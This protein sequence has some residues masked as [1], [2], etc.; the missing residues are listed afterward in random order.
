MGHFLLSFIQKCLGRKP[1]V[2]EYPYKGHVLWKSPAKGPRE[3]K[4]YRSVLPSS[5]A[6]LL[7]SIWVF[8]PFNA[9]ANNTGTGFLDTKLGVLGLVHSKVKGS[10][11][12]LH[13]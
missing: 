4:M 2:R 10:R 9:H 8:H 13:F 11:K 1:C 3:N 12:A 7:L 6:P 5:P